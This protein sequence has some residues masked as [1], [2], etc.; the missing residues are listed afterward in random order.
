[1]DFNRRT[2]IGAG[3]ATAAAACAG[4]VATRALALD[5]AAVARMTTPVPAAVK[6]AEPPS[7]LR[8]AIAALDT[9]RIAQRDLVGLVDFSAHSSKPRFQLVDVA[10]GT[11]VGS[12]LVAH[13][14]GSDPAHTGWLQSFSNTPG[15]NASSRGSYLVG[16]R[17]HGEHGL[18]RRLAGLD[19]D[20]DQAMARAIVIHS[21][22]YVDARL[23]DRQGQ[24]GRSQGCFAVTESCIEDV[25][26]RLGEGRLLF[27]AR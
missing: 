6:T 26:A 8:Q 3:A 27:A 23:I 25:I 5:P 21:A 24:I 18:A 11:I 10:N 20:N 9:H 12:Y 13:G 2:F 19:P 4:A 1:M 15:S 17:Y 22:A 16:N 7:L 14:R